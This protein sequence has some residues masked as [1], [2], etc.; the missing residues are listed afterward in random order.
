M[1]SGSQ[2]AFSAPQQP[3]RVILALQRLIRVRMSATATLSFT[4]TVRGPQRHEAG[5]G[6]LIRLSFSQS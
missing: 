4:S 1:C 6:H 5:L 3:E 2:G